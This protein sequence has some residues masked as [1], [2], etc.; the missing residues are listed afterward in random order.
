MITKAKRLKSIG[1]IGPYAKL[2]DDRNESAHPNGNIFY[3]TAVL[4]T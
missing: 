1:K 4:H 3:S 2:V